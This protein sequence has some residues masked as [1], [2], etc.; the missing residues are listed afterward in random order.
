MSSWNDCRD[1]CISYNDDYGR[2]SCPMCELQA[3]LS[4]AQQEIERLKGVLAKR[5]PCD[6]WRCEDAIRGGWVGE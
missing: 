5:P 6:C 1:C 4:V 3:T 2:R